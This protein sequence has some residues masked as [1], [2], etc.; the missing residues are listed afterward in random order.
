MGIFCCT[1]EIDS[2]WDVY[3]ANSFLLTGSVD[4]YTSSLL[5]VGYSPYS[6]WPSRR[7]P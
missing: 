7:L 4:F 5:R 1:A 3:F 2:G 6:M